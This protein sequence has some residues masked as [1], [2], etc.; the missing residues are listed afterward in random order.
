MLIQLGWRCH[1]LRRAVG[2]SLGVAGFSVPHAFCA[3]TIRTAGARFVRAQWL[4]SA[5]G[6]GGGVELGTPAPAAPSRGGRRPT[7]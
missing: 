4:V 5:K 6:P 3:M 2:G 7:A 1:G